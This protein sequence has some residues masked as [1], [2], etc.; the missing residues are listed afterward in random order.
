MKWMRWMDEVMKVDEVMEVV[1]RW[2]NEM[3]DGRWMDEMKDGWMR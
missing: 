2:M 1:R 3:K